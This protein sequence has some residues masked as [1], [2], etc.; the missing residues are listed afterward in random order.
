MQTVK[1]QTALSHFTFFPIFY[2][3]HLVL[4]KPPYTQCQILTTH[5][6]SQI[7]TFL[8]LRFYCAVLTMEN[9]VMYSLHSILG[10]PKTHQCGKRG[11]PLHIG[12]F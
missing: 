6:F 4:A 8:N 5:T 10:S 12:V 9:D 7:Y 2:T 11:A 3:F 1:L